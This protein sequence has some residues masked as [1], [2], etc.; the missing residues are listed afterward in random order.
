[1]DQTSPQ[2]MRAL[3]DFRR[4]RQRAILEQIIANLKNESDDLLDFDEVREKLHAEESISQ[5]LQEIPLDAI[6]GSV[7]RYR[8]FT[9]SFLPRR[10]TGQTRWASV[11]TALEASAFPPIAV[12]QIGDVYFVLD[13]NHRVSIARQSGAQT[14]QAYVTEVKTKVPLS[15]DMQ[16]DDLICQAKYADFL[17]ETQLDKSH[18][19]AD[20]MVTAPGQYRVLLQQIQQHQR[21][22]TRQTGEA[23]SLPHAAALW[24][25]D[26]YLPLIELIRERGIL[27]SFPDRTETDLYTWLV[28]HREELSKSLGWDVASEAAALDLVSRFSATPA[29][30]MERVKNRIL[31]ALTPEPLEAGPTPG[32]WRQEHLQADRLFRDILVPLSDKETGWR[33]L[34]QALTLAQ[35]E[36]GRLHALHVAANSSIEQGQLESEFER[37]C[38]DASVEGDFAVASGELVERIFEAGRWADLIVYAIAHPPQEQ[39]LARLSSDFNTLIRQTP[40]PVLVVPG[41]TSQMHSALLSYDGSPKAKEALFIAAYIASRWEISLTV[42]T[43]IDNFNIETAVLDDARQYLK[44][45]DVEA[46]FVTAQ[47]PVTDAIVTT[48]T[49]HNSDFLIMGGY[50]FKP[51]LEVV[52]GSTVDEILRLHRWPV[53]ICR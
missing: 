2:F 4:A 19:D 51:L 25:T 36:G 14:I 43:V 23:V 18:P 31:E 50:G 12:Y 35:R 27:H 46:T 8:D 9:R 42:L 33:T 29:K 6:V 11:K 47:A 32:E 15:P 3:R 44:S 21:K 7:G 40:R 30:L 38:S 37:R 20:F 5:G 41:A 10:D 45:R 52:L 13:G 17:E 1:M 26:V 39:P 24:Y 48:A 49:K 28:A 34:E 22:L 16:P 53:L